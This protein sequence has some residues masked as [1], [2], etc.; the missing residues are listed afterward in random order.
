MTKRKRTNTQAMI[1]KTLHRKLWIEQ[2]EPHKK[3]MGELKGKHF[4]PH[5]WHPILAN[6][7]QRKLYILQGNQCLCYI[8]VSRYQRE[9]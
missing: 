6:K 2:H 3:N 7:A 9:N 1:Y 4:L 5:Q 8:G